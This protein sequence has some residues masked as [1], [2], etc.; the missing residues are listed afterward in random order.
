MSWPWL[1]G[2]AASFVAACHVP[3]LLHAQLANVAATWKPHLHEGA[4]LKTRMEY[5]CARLWTIAT[6]GALFA[7]LASYLF[8]IAEHCGMLR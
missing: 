5:Q 4:S 8:L 2:A 7:G 6:A 1:L 3:F